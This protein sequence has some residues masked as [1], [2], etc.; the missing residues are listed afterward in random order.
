MK[1]RIPQ[2]GG[3][4]QDMIKKVKKLQDDMQAK[5]E[6]LDS[7]EYD[8]ASV[9]GM[10]TVKIKGTK[11]IIGIKIDPSIV[12]ADDIEMLEDMLTAA[13]NE[14][15]NKVE[16]TNENEMQKLTGGINLPNI[17]GF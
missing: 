5:Q 2:Q 16:N 13:V 3:N 14:A 4:Q 17:P 1:V 15:I 8:V 7:R 6:E 9:G 11:E 10:V 12:T